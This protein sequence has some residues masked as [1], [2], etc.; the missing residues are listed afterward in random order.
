MTNDSRTP[1]EIERDIVDERA[2]MSGTINDLQNKFSVDAVMKD[3]G[4]MFLGQ[5]SDLGRTITRTVG[6]NPAAVMLVGVGLAW[7]FVGQDRRSSAAGSHP[8]SGDAWSSRRRQQSAAH[9]HNRSGAGAWPSDM[10]YEDSQRHWYG[11]TDTSDTDESGQGIMGKIRGEARAVSD[12]VSEAAENMGESARRLTE[13]LAHGTEDFSDAARARVVAA[14]RAAHEARLSSQAAMNRA[15]RAATTFFEEQPLVAGALAVGVGAALA[16]A[17][18]RSR[19]EDDALG[20]SSD[21]LFD[22]AQAVFREERDKAKA[23]LRA[24]GTDLQDEIR[25]TGSDIAGLLPEDKNLGE[26]I[27]DHAAD[28]AARVIDGAKDEAGRQGLGR[29]DT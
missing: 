7:L 25:E 17:L 5:G 26:V 4:D 6:R 13:R 18:P 27:V 24:A 20:D 19:F 21:R 12:T 10:S 14:R 3:L 11:D 16:S 8:A 9:R 22:E 23:V 1:D 28:A 29:R 2:R 15:G